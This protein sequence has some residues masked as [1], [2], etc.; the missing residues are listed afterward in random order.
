MEKIFKLKKDRRG[1]ISFDSNSNFC[2][3]RRRF[4]VK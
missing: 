3:L 4:Y 1:G 2:T